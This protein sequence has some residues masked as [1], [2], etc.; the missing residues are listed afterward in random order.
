M[1]GQPAKAGTEFDFL[2][3]LQTCGSDTA[4]HSPGAEHPVLQDVSCVHGIYPLSGQLAPRTFLSSFPLSSLLDSSFCTNGMHRERLPDPGHGIA[5]K[6]L[7][8]ERQA[9]S[10]T[11]AMSVCT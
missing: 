8:A 11:G 9:C 4:F 7:Y 6:G 10:G 1:P 2:I 3:Q 5:M